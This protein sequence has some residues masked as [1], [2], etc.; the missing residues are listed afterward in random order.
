MGPMLL[1]ALIVTGSTL[2]SVAVD[3][4]LNALQ[5]WGGTL[6]ADAFWSGPQAASPALSRLAG[7]EREIDDLLRGGNFRI[8]APA[9]EVQ[10]DVDGSEMCRG[11][12]QGASAVGDQ[13]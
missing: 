1:A 2:A 7:E 6:Y 10:R 5:N 8:E 4:G 12:C 13:P 11:Q 3:V 9:L